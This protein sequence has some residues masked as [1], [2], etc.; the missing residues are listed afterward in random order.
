MA[1]SF[2][3]NFDSTSQT[4]SR[5]CRGS[6]IQMRSHEFKTR[7]NRKGKCTHDTALSS[8]SAKLNRY[9][10]EWNF[11]STSEHKLNLNLAQQRNKIRLTFSAEVEAVE[12]FTASFVLDFPSTNREQKKKIMP[13]ATPYAPAIKCGGSANDP[14]KTA[15][16]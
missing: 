2:L 10:W 8:K 15:P 7:S 1:R 16:V 13:R 3:I 11:R 9:S 12:A 14:R 6:T 4:W 5:I